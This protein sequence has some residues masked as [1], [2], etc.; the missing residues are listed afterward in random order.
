MYCWKHQ[1][2]IL[3]SGYALDVVPDS[4]FF[5]ILQGAATLWYTGSPSLPRSPKTSTPWHH[6]PCIAL[7]FMVGAWRRIS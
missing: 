7:L 2:F 6:H 3:F 1:V 5:R 4:V